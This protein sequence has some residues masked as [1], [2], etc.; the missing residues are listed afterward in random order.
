M[1]SEV[2]RKENRKEMQWIC[3]NIANVNSKKLLILLWLWVWGTFQLIGQTQSEA[4]NIFLR[5]ENLKHAAITFEMVDLSTGRRIAAHNESQSLASASNLKLVT[6]ATALDILGSDFSY[7]T[8]LFYDGVIE[9]SVLNGNI[10]IEG[11]GDPTL[12]SEFTDEEQERFLTVWLKAIQQAG[13][14]RIKGDVIVLDQLFGYTGISPKWLWE[15]LGN[16]Y[17]AGAY[18][19]SIFDNIYRLYLQSSSPGNRTKILHTTPEMKDLRFTNTIIATASEPA[20]AFISGAPFSCERHLHGSVSANN[21]ILTVKGDIPDPGLFLARYFTDYLQ[22]SGIPVSGKAVTY[23]LSPAEPQAKRELAV[24]RSPDLNAIVRTVNV[25]SNNH[26]AEHLY[27]LLTLKKGIDIPAYWKQKGLDTSALFQ[28]DGSG[29][30]PADAVSADFLVQ[31]LAYMNKQS[32]GFYAS[33]PI[34]GKEGTVASFLKGTALEGKARIKSGSMTAVQSFAGYIDKNGKRY[35]FAL[36]INHFTG[37]RA[38]LRK[39]IE[40]LLTFVLS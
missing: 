32:N 29:L 14:Q 2:K 9:N 7:C 16:Y 30:S 33:L 15:D 31:L 3:I 37:S 1:E 20:G 23:R 36:I 25:H 39:E 26:Y 22:K 28:Y 40:K 13:I 27:K 17:A 8:S 6:T 18:G 19:I 21:S 4:L 35:A 12:G 10:Y 38:E 5:S 24:I 11:S 34:A